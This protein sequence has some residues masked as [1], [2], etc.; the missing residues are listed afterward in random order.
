MLALLNDPIPR[1]DTISTN[2]TMRSP[3]F[4]QQQL[5]F[6]W[7]IQKEILLVKTCNHSDL[8]YT[9]EYLGEVCPTL[10]G[11]SVY[12][13]ADLLVLWDDLLNGFPWWNTNFWRIVLVNIQPISTKGDIPEC[14]LNAMEGKALNSFLSPSTT[15]S[16][17]EG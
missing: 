12:H 14:I 4:H 8:W 3:N 5:C 17:A 1:T 2:K 9:L 6:S 16:W 11:L 13:F 15:M 10:Q 7:R